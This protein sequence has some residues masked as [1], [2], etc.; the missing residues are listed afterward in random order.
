MV[1]QSQLHRDLEASLGFVRAFQNKQTNKQ[2]HT[3]ANQKKERKKRI[4][5]NT[6]LSTGIEG[7]G[8]LGQGQRTPTT[9]VCA[10]EDRVTHSSD[11]C[12]FSKAWVPW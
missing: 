10:P 6:N 5:F 12:E 3:I 11:I 8:C 4:N 7:E 9:W 1:P 2:P